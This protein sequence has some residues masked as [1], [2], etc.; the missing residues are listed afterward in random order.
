MWSR[1]ELLVIEAAR[2]TQSFNIC[3]NV[4]VYCGK[5]FDDVTIW[6]MSFDGL[7]LKRG[8]ELC[9]YVA[10]ERRRLGDVAG[11][12]FL[13]IAVSNFFIHIADILLL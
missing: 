13:S 10:C 1:R 4:Y 7:E 8:A 9:C 12:F 5:D 11:N 2:Y 3:E 6:A